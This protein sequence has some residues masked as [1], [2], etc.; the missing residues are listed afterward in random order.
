MTTIY[1]IDKHIVHTTMAECG[2]K[3]FQLHA[4]HKNPVDV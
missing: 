2:V 4:T 1:G 3:L